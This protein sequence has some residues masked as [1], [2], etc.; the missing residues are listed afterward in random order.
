[1]AHGHHRRKQKS[2]AMSSPQSPQFPRTTPLTED[3]WK[4]IADPVVALYYLPS[5][6]SDRKL[7][8]FGCYCCRRIPGISSDE[9]C[10][11][12]LDIAECYADGLIDAAEFG[13]R[14]LAEDRWVGAQL[15]QSLPSGGAVGTTLALDARVAATAARIVAEGQ[16]W[17][18]E[19]SWQA[20]LMR[21][22]FASPCRSVNMQPAW[23][24]IN[25]VGLSQAIY[26]ERAFDRL[27]ILGDALEDA[28]CTDAAMLD[29]C[30]Q[31]GEHVRG[32]WLLDL[33]SGRS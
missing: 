8:L 26:S 13:R 6:P 19:R 10:R 31:L 28:G 11:Q 18:A 16:D 15:F 22:L 12:A 9:A 17:H 5:R 33:V 1:M 27:P 24:T 7:R 20:G 4:R 21:E 3:E 29:H 14:Y 25:V 32:C 2:T 30:R 23:Q